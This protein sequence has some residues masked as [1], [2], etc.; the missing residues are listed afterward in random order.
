[1]IT[2]YSAAAGVVAYPGEETPG[3][4]IV[5]EKLH[6]ADSKHP[7]PWSVGDWNKF[8]YSY[9]SVHEAEILVRRL[10]FSRIWILW[11]IYCARQLGLINFMC[12]PTCARFNF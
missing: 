12:G 5:F 11:E 4:R 8:K 6:E 1:M 10:Y 7:S 3:N 2:I 9:S